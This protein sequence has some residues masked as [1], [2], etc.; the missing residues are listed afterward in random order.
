MC[1]DTIKCDAPTWYGAKCSGRAWR[2]DIA[3]SHTQSALQREYSIFCVRTETSVTPVPGA[4]PHLGSV[5]ILHV[6][7]ARQPFESLVPGAGGD[8]ST[9]VAHCSCLLGENT[10]QVVQFKYPTKRG[11]QHELC[12]IMGPQPSLRPSPASVSLRSWLAPLTKRRPRFNSQSYALPTQRDCQR[13][14]ANTV[15]SYPGTLSPR[16]VTHI[17]CKHVKPAVL[18]SRLLH[19]SLWPKYIFASET[20]MYERERET[21]C[22]VATSRVLLHKD[23]ASEARAFKSDA[24]KRA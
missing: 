20:R 4:V 22:S 14:V 3:K 9:P 7:G 5:C 6:G 19:K 24:D 11:L 2:D 15:L 1:C 12:L 18:A 8:G 16:V 17:S 21:A 23:T 10:S 13:A